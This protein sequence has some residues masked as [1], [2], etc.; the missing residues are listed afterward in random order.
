M[1]VSFDNLY[2]T[3]FI[4]E[5]TLF[6]ILNYSLIIEGDLYDTEIPDEVVLIHLPQWA[7][8]LG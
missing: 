2:N 8:L 4:I 6:L 3:D 7:E 1:A 5:E